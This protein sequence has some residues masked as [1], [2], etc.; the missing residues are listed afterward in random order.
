MLKNYRLTVLFVVTSI[1]LIVFAVLSQVIGVAGAF[2]DVGENASIQVG[3]A[4]GVVLRG[5]LVTMAWLFL[6]LTGFIVVADVTIQQSRARER[7]EEA[8]IEQATA[9]ARAE[10]LHGSRTRI[11]EVSESLRRDIAHHLHGS[12][13]N[14]LILL[15]HKVRE[16]EPM[17]SSEELAQELKSL[18][19]N[20]GDVI[21]AE[22][23]PI[24]HQ[25]YPS[26]LRRGLIPALQS[27]G[28]QFES[29]IDLQMELDP[30]LVQRERVDS[31]LIP[32]RVRL[33]AYRIA[34]NALANVIKHAGADEVS[35]VVKTDTER[36]LRLIVRDDGHGFDVDAASQGL[37]IG[38][39]R[40][41]ADVV[42]G[43]CTI[44][45]A[46]G[47]GTDITVTLPLAELAEG[48]QRR[49]AL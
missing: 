9:L 49:D 39:M 45:S 28:D 48:R 31:N 41:Y 44:R 36:G 6:A 42:G 23:R 3:E 5:T 2:G 47:S 24:T 8:R 35:L 38:T 32:E 46:P 25:L 43:E 7:A 29:A 37:G 34:E 17:A 13:Q 40:D 16:L 11:V 1:A 4:Q 15:M 33:S 12:V 30:D 10:E 21:E 14:R 19:K 22:I 18:H 20:I 26:I 27:L